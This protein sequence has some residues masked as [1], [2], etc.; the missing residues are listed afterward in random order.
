MAYSKNYARV[1]LKVGIILL[2]LVVTYAVAFQR[3]IH[4]VDAFCARVSTDTEVAELPRI[5]QSLGVKLQGPSVTTDSG[6]SHVFAAVV[7]AFTMGD[8]GCTMRA[9][10]MS[11]KV[12]SKRLGYRE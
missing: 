6:G 11:G 5:A 1:S 8:Y 9:A 10:T 2:L 12:E 4:Q 7:S 3:S